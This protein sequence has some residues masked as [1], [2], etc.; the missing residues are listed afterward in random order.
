MSGL[1]SRVRRLEQ[2]QAADET[3]D[4]FRD[5]DEVRL[6]ARM[7]RAG[8]RLQQW[9]RLTDEQA[10]A[11]AKHRPA[12]ASRLAELETQPAA[13]ATAPDRQDVVER[14]RAA[15]IRLAAA[16]VERRAVEQAFRAAEAGGT[17]GRA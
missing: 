6:M 5:D 2:A 13:P 10:S 7:I 15:S 1:G 3:A 4:R 16:A 9:H 12:L 14:L 17:V 11:W 8:D